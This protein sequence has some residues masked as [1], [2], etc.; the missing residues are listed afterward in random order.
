MNSYGSP[1]EHQPLTWVKGYPVYG[2]HALMLGFVASMLATTVFMGIGA[3]GILGSLHFSSA[4][5]LRGEIW[6]IATYGLVNPPSIWFAVDMLM[7]VWFGRDL[8]KFYGRRKLLILFAG[9]YFLPP[10]VLTAFGLV[11]PNVLSGQSGSFGLFVAFATLYPNVAFI[12]NILAKWLAVILVGI[13]TLAALSNRDMAGLIALWT[14]VAFAHGF[15]RD[16]QGRFNFP[17][18]SNARPKPEPEPV[19]RPVSRPRSAE[20]VSAGTMAE[21]DALLDKIAQSGMG[22]LTAKERA[23]LDA[24]RSEMKR[25][26]QG[27]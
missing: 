18:F 27:R 16:Q 7:L 25:R 19:A 9:L 13:Y 24:A 6:R 17:R 15:V 26:A 10:L 1:E 21:V 8:E 3:Q 12:F 23:K 2:A 5:V 4:L 14:G 20:S 11:Q 22:S